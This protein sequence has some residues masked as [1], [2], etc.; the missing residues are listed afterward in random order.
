MNIIN[1]NKNYKMTSNLVVNNCKF[2]VGKLILIIGPMYS[3]KTTTI[4]DL[5]KKYGFSTYSPYFG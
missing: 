4:L 3:G 5:Y 2:D 1:K